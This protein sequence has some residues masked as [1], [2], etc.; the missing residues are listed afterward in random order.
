[1]DPDPQQWFER[2]LQPPAHF[3]LGW[4]DVP[5][6]RQLRGRMIIT[7]PTSLSTHQQQANPPLSLGNVL[8]MR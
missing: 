7:V 1:V 3:L 2:F 4:E 5:T 6:V 8:G